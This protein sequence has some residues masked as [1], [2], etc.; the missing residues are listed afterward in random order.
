MNLNEKEK[1]VLTAGLILAAVFAAIFAY[2][3]FFVFADRIA[4]N[5]KV[6]KEFVAKSADLQKE[7]DEMNDLIK[8]EAQIQEM[9]NRLKRAMNKLPNE[10]RPIEFLD[11]L[12]TTLEKT[13]VSQ[14]RVAPGV[15]KSRTLY[16]EIPYE[17]QGSA[18]YHE[19]GQFLNLIE[20]NPRRFMRVNSFDVRNN[21]ARPTVHPITVGI[22]TFMFN[23]K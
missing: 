12:R 4:K 17:V 20:C 11:E 13:G 21:N 7:L 10:S 15:P 14:R 3:Q 23:K 16:T 6:K 22:S 1:D 8:E 2:L 5:E 18:R 19:F 9:Y